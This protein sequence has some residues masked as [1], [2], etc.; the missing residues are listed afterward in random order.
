MSKR[1]FDSE[2]NEDNE[3]KQKHLESIN[4]L[5]QLFILINENS[6]LHRYKKVYK[7]V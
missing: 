4:N 1:K 3:I 7:T 5:N 6:S 2:N